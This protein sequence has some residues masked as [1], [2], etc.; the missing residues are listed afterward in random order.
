VNEDSEVDGMTKAL[1]RKM[2][3]ELARRYE[4]TSNFVVVD[5]H[6]LTAGKAVEFRAELR[7]SEVRMN[8]VKNSV[9]RHAFARIGL[10]PLTEFLKEMNGVV[11]G[12]DAVAIAKAVVDFRKK[13]DNVP[14][15]RGG[16]VEGKP[17]DA[18]QVE[19]I[20]QLPS[21]EQIL[22]NFLATM[23]APA[24]SFVR[25]LNEIPAAFVRALDAIR[26]QKEKSA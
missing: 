18:R 7:R 15:V 5:Y 9:A 19:A 21:R 25:V 17:V 16:L 23:N 1:R 10:A 14:K 22:A 2:V 12:P 20:S 3:D 8:V 13:N 11:Y 4:G 26:E 6:G 24:S